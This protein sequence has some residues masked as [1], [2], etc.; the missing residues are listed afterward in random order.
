MAQPIDT[1]KYKGFYL[2]GLTRVEH[3][4]SESPHSAEYIAQ[5]LFSSLEKAISQLDAAMSDSHTHK[6]LTDWVE[7]PHRKG[8]FIRQVE[9]FNMAMRGGIFWIRLFPAPIDDTTRY[10]IDW[11]F[12]RD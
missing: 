9:M 12:D 3:Q 8:H 7:H 1:Q 6:F 11:A 5:H 2:A 4:G 10:I